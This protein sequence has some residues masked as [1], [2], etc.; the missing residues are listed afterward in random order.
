MARLTLAE[1]KALAAVAK[2]T[3]AN[4]TEAKK[5]GGGGRLLPEGYSL[6]RIVQLVQYGNQ[7]QEFGGKA[8]APA[9]EFQLGFELYDEGF[10]NE[11]GTPYVTRTF[12][13]AESQFEKATA[14]KMFK[15]LNWQN[16]HTTWIDL[17]GELVMVKIV[18]YKGGKDKK[19]TKSKIDLAGFLPPLDPR[20]RKPYEAPELKEDN[21]L[22]FLWD[23][24]NLENW[25][26]LH[27]TQQ[28]D[29][30]GAL[31]FSGSEVEGMLLEAGRDVKAKPKADKQSEEKE[32]EADDKP[33]AAP[34][35]D[36]SAMAMPTP[37]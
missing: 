3:E 2:E 20:S 6:A 23:Y 10:C 15:L 4:M 35:A 18:H 17:V 7:P 31:N 11:D 27:E 37:E 32:E 22:V 14:F 26:A 16:I 25:D 30:L 5:G 12:R 28:S 29:I 13:I 33:E 1:I 19:E 34:A 36:T 24:P 9:P 8:K 21:L